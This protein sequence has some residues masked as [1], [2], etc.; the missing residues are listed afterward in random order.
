MWLCVD[1]IESGLVVLVSDEERTYRIPVA[2]YSRLTGI[3]PAESDML[4]AETQG[5][6]ILSAAYDE[7][8]TVSRKAAAQARLD[9]LF[10]N[11]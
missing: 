5:D 7:T 11:N 3:P 4:R 9:R 8:E 10:G 1:R 2:E 6:R